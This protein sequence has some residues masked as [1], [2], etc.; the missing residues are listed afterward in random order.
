M[1]WRGILS[2]Q[3]QDLPARLMRV[4]THALSHVYRWVVIRRNRRFDQQR[5]EIRRVNVP[6]ISVGNLTAG[7]TGK[8]P[9]VIWLCQTL[10]QLGLRPA[11]VSRG[12]GGQ[13]DAL[14]DEGREIRLRLPDVP[15]IQN[16]QRAEGAQVAIDQHGANV[17]VL[18]D[19]FQH[20]RLHRDLDLVLIDA[21]CPWG[22]G[23][24]CREVCCVNR[25]KVCVG[26]MR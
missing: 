13:G 6:V 21:T 5:T 8:T 11:I 24:Y 17:I 14:N 19:G 3:R 15:V 10:Q 18:D 20:R 23:M 12:Y 9:L 2:G 16:R 25:L 4:T 22:Y 7:G 1:D 26:L